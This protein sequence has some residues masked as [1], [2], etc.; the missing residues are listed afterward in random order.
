MSNAYTKL[1]VKDLMTT[2]VI[3]VSCTDNLRSAMDSMREHKVKCLVVDKRTPTDAWGMLTY[4]DIL[5][6]I[7]RTEGDVGLLNVYDLATKPAL[8]I[9]AGMEV[10]LAARMMLNF[11]VKRL[12]VTGNDDEIVGILTMHDVVG[13]IIEKIDS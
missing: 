3:T 2:E 5:K 4:T 13:A 7:A 12:V 1:L 10:R 6:T 8:T 9:P 11:E